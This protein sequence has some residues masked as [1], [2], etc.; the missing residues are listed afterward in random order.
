M[1][2]HKFSSYKVLRRHGG[3]YYCEHPEGGEIECKLK[4]SFKKGRRTTNLVVVGDH[5]RLE[6]FPGQKFKALLVEV[7]ERQTVMRRA[8][9]YK[10]SYGGRDEREAQALIANIDQVL[11]TI[12]V[13][14]PD[15][16]PLLFDR[17]LCIVEYM[18]IT[19]IIL[20]NKW[21]LL[22]PSDLKDFEHIKACYEGC[23]FKVLTLSL[24]SGQNM[25]EFE[26]ILNGKTSFLMGP[27]GAGKSSLVNS[28]CPTLDIRLGEWSERCKTGP[29]TTTVTQI[30]PIAEKTYIADTAGFSQVYLSHIFWEELRFCYPEYRHLTCKYQDCLH[31]SEDQCLIRQSVREGLL[32]SGR[33]DRYLKLL[34][35]CTKEQP[36][37]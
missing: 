23:G 3:F 16:H 29:Q 27:S 9:G 14:E 22:E 20:L 1:T 12:P 5:V 25:H 18:E 28:I 32:D 34:E 19:P 35:E 8:K 36:W 30:Y 37:A 2:K 7:C 13:K 17:F 10:R 24:E 11:L 6:F 21:D 33:Y 31:Q 4:G 15:F 26:S